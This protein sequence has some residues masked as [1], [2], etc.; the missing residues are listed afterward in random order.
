MLTFSR[1]LRDGLPIALGYLSVSF[2]FGMV[3]VKGLLPIWAPILTSTT[4]F[5]GTGQFVGIDLLIKNSSLI[6]ITFTVLVIN[7]RYLLMSFSLSQR[8]PQD[9]STLKRMVIAF[10]NTDEVFGVAMSKNQTLNFK[11]MC[12]LIL[13]SYIGW[14][15][16]TTLGACISTLL[17]AIVSSALGIA[18]Y[19]MFLAIIVPPI[20]HSKAIAYTVVIAASMSTAFYFLP[21]VDQIPSGF[22]IIICG[23]FSSILVSIA[24]PIHSLDDSLTSHEKE[25]D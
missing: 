20:K 7:I 23:V 17:P 5:T 24:Y 14:L 21:Y 2:A 3:A 15:L 25:A 1:G 4:N 11:Y 22:R 13:S 10:G 8:L 12:G 18:I 16:G 19:A 9:M 6:E